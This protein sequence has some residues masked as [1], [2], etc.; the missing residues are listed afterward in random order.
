MKTMPAYQPMLRQTAST[1]MINSIPVSASRAVPPRAAMPS[2]SP[3]K[4]A[5]TRRPEAKKSRPS[6]AP[7]PTPIVP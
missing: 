2:T 5:G 1:P 3:L 4:N 7:Q 6:R